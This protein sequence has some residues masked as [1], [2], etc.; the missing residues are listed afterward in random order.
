[1][2]N[3]DIPIDLKN[4]LEKRKAFIIIGHKNPDGDCLS[5]QLAL[6]SL[7]QRRGKKVYLLSPG[8]FNRSEIEHQEILFKS[9]VS[10]DWKA[11]DPLVVVVDCSTIDRIGY[12]ADEIK[13]LDIAV[14]D[15]HDS[16]SSFG[17]I[18]FIRPEAP[19]VTFLIHKIIESFNMIPSSEEADL[20]LFG[21][22]TDTGFFRH[23][24]SDSHE[25]F[26]SVAKLTESG[27]SPKQAYS[28]MYGGRSLQSKLLLGRLLSRIRTELEGKLIITFE[29]EEDFNEFG[30]D[31]RDSDTFYQQM[32][33]V[34]GVEVIILIRYESKSEISVGLRSK[35]YAD[36][37]EVAKSFGGGGHKK[38]AGF[39]WIGS[40]EEITVK[41]IKIMRKIL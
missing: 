23:L 18:Q 29:T 35:Y 32:Q 34:K 2:T 4:M 15:H 17:D 8:P 30:K 1:M 38:A 41:L 13:D 7:L 14:I 33:A 37:G 21:L 40:A 28:N 11:D 3:Y 31:N 16:G 22:A 36:I 24:E 12:L 9:H 19:S 26:K 25:I 6:G 20:L 5:S 27:A 39:T 10:D